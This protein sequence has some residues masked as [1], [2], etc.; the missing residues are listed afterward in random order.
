MPACALNKKPA[1]GISEKKFE[2]ALIEYMQNANFKREPKIP[3]E[4]QQD[5]DKLHQKIISIEKQRRNT[6]KPGPWS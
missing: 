5:Y 6:K 2:K 1:I 3:Q 4:K